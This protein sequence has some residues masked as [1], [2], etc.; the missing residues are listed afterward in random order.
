MHINRAVLKISSQKTWLS[1]QSEYSELQ[2]SK[3]SQCFKR[4]TEALFVKRQNKWLANYLKSTLPRS[5][6]ICWN[7]V[8]NSTWCRWWL[9]EGLCLLSEEWRAQ[10]TGTRQWTT[11]P[12]N[13]VKKVLIYFLWMGKQYLHIEFG[14]LN[15]NTLHAM[16]RFK[17]KLVLNDKENRRILY[18][19]LLWED[20]LSCMQFLSGHC[21]SEIWS[22]HKLSCQNNS[23]QLWQVSLLFYFQTNS[24]KKNFSCSTHCEPFF[25]CIFARQDPNVSKASSVRKEFLKSRH[26]F[27]HSDYSKTPRLEWRGPVSPTYKTTERLCT[28]FMMSFRLI[29]CVYDS[30]RPTT[31]F[32]WCRNPFPQTEVAN[33]IH[34][35][36]T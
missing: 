36:Q 11:Q 31:Y 29:S 15:C 12:M 9:P 17:A 4:C 26:C 18:W 2:T 1:I 16:W 34:S 3:N 19:G 28:V 21:Q 27:S 5:C 20:C 30:V 13:G 14:P 32:S 22:F 25:P 8:S 7:Q 35:K 33:K 10:H 24:E 6:P 23:R